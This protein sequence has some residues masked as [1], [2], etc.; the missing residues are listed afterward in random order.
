MLAEIATGKSNGAIAD[1]VVLTKRAVEKHVNSIF[2]KLRLSDSQDASRRAEGDAPV[3]L[4]RA[5]RR[6]TMKSHRL[7]AR[8]RPRGRRRLKPVLR[9]GHVADL[10]G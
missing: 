9:R 6:G 2:S 4:R 7:V 3:P 1:A 5:E 8:R 10:T